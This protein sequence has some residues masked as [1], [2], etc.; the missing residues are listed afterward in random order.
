MEEEGD[1]LVVEKNPV[2]SVSAPVT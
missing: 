2:T 1:V